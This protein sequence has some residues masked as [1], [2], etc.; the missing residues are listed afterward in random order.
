MLREAANNESLLLK[1]GSRN[2]IFPMWRAT[3]SFLKF[4]RLS[5][6][7][8]PKPLPPYTPQAFHLISSIIIQVV[9][10][11]EMPPRPCATLRTIHRKS[12]GSCITCRVITH[13]QPL[14]YRVLARSVPR[15]CCPP[16]RIPV[17]P[18]S[19]GSPS[20]ADRTT[21]GSPPASAESA[22]APPQGTVSP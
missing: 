13:R 8:S 16:C 20:T 6:M 7:K 11:Y 17:A 10:V 14:L 15:S 22:A 18:A 21:S 4:L 3:Y 12:F 2:F 1:L 5:C 9:L 19:R